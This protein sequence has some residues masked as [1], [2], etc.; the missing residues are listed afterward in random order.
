MGGADRIRR[1]FLVA[2]TGLGVSTL[3]AGCSSLTGSEPS[4]NLSGSG[5]DSSAL[6]PPISPSDYA[7]ASAVE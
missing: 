7:E 2:S 6:I 4:T 5:E 1:E 3:C